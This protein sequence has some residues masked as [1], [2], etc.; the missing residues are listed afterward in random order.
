MTETIKIKSIYLSSLVTEAPL[1]KPEQ[2]LP[3]QPKPE[4]LSA[5]EAISPQ[6]C[7]PQESEPRKREESKERPPS[8]EKKR[9]VDRHFPRKEGQ[10][11]V[12]RREAEETTQQEG[13][14]SKSKLSHRYSDNGKT[15][16]LPSLPHSWL[17]V[18]PL[19]DGL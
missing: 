15:V 13:G 3:G 6:Q 4:K 12:S 7:Q 17:C 5:V 19:R 11:P 18:V 8:Q 10:E 16:R 1:E 2:E 14:G 9:D